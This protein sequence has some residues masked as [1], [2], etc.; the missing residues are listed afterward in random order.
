MLLFL[1]CGYTKMGLLLV[2]YLRL[3][4][5]RFFKNGPSRPLFSL[6]SSFQRKFKFL[7]KINVIK[8]LSS[9]QR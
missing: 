8:C 5:K 9:I 4:W 6:F 7:Q 1:F 2:T 3:N